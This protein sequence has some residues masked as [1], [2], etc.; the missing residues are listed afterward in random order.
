MISEV[1]EMK[2]LNIN[3]CIIKKRKEKGIT[4]EQL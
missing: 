2:E 1:N 4:Q 3:K